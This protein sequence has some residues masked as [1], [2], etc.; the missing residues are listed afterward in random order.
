MDPVNREEGPGTEPPCCEG[1]AAQPSCCGGAAPDES[2]ASCD[3]GSACCCGPAPS[4]GSRLKTDAGP[5]P[6]VRTTLDRADRLGTW[7]ARWAVGRDDYTVAP[8]LYAVGEPTGDSPVL[9]SANY[10]MSFDRLRSVLPGRNAWILVIDTK[11]INVW[12][13][14]GKGTFGTDEIVQRVQAVAL[15]LVVAHRRLIVPQLGAPGVAAHEVRA[16]CGFRVFYGP[17]RAEDLPAF[18]DAG[19]K[20]TPEMRLVT[21]GLRDRAVLIPVELVLGMKTALLLAAAVV[22]LGGLGLDGYSLA[23]VRSIGLPGAGLLLGAFLAST[24]LGPALLPW[25][26]GR[27][28]SIKGAVLGAILVAALAGLAW[29]GL[30][31]VTW[32]HLAAWALVVPALSSFVVMNFTGASTFT[33]L[34]G[35]LREMKIAIPVQ[36]AAAGIG[37]ALWIAGLFLGGGQGS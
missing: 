37:A 29:N 18:L 25:L 5:V 12:C 26:P 8:G 16:R 14:A 4:K 9:V 21:F 10:K 33:S 31:A 28:F 24:V 3:P 15:D 11:G 1:A 27:A 22:L 30:A 23:R 36:I 2:A 13:A 6:R 34:S 17:V 19:M 20:T 35:V 32:F 7:K